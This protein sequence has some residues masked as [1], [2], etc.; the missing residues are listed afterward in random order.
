VPDRL[1]DAEHVVH[2]LNNALT[3]INGYAEVAL[4]RLHDQDPLRHIVSEIHAAGLRAA[5]LA[6]KL[7]E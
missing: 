7:R 5:E 3:A 2:E 1:T 6:R 4:R